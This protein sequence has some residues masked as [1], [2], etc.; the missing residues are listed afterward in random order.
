[1]KNYCERCRRESAGNQTLSK[2]TTL[3]P[4]AELSSASAT[5]CQRFRLL[6]EPLD[7]F[8]PKA[9]ALF[10]PR[11]PSN[12]R[13]RSKMPLIACS[14][15]I[16]KRRSLPG[17]RSRSIREEWN[18]HRFNDPGQTQYLQPQEQVIPGVPRTW[19]RY[20]HWIFAAISW[21]S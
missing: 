10:R 9:L 18:D 21:R 11:L 5:N 2:R 14:W 1:M 13:S 12:S 15:S 7:A 19:A 16:Q 8:A 4:L 6:S 3:A 17:W 20:S